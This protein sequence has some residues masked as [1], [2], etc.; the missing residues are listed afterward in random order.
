VEILDAHVPMLDD[1]IPMAPEDPP[2][3]AR[4]RVDLEGERVVLHRD[5]F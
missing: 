1:A 3:L 5:G 4:R 2:Y